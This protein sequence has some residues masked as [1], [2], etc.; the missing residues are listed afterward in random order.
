MPI[1]GHPRRDPDRPNSSIRLLPRVFDGEALILLAVRGSAPG[2]RA[3]G[4][5][6]GACFADP[7]SPWS[8]PLCSTNSAADR[9]A[10]FAGFIAPTAES[11]FPCSCIIGFGSSPSRC[12][13]GR[14]IA[15]GQTWDLPTSDAFL[16][17]V[18]CSSTPAGW[19]CLAYRPCSCCVRL[20]TR[21]PLLRRAHF[22]AQSQTPRH[23]CVRFVAGVT[24]GSRNT[25]YRAA[26][27][28][29][30]RTGL[31]PVGLHQ[32]SLAPSQSAPR[33]QRRRGA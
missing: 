12:G 25:C 33:W 10:L 9:S 28:G 18:T 2:S 1:A 15:A 23:C 5:E 8:L 31:S 20:S 22:V 24:V 3:P 13:P 29:L 7:R 21:S 6:S 27:Y 17:R 4:S 14:N 26:R 32:L 19:Q 16:L 11:D 30:T